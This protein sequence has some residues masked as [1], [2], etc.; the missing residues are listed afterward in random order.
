MV[1]WRKALECA[2]VAGRKGEGYG[3]LCFGQVSPAFSG[4]GLVTVK[5][6]C[7]GFEDI[8]NCQ[9]PLP[10]LSFL[11]SSFLFLEPQSLTP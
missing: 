10:I 7:P 8:L 3:R 11:L 1:P 6:A 2:R 4:L 5:R 9:N